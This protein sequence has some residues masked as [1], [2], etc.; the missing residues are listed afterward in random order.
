[1]RN[2]VVICDKKYKPIEITFGVGVKLEELGVD[3]YSDFKP[4]KGLAGYIAVMADCSMG[5]AIGLIEKHMADGGELEE[6]S[7]CFYEAI[8]ESGFFRQTAKKTKKN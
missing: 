2:E 5:E 6:V 1:M 7:A 3:L 4:L 8:K